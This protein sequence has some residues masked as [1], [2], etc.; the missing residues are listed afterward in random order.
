[1]YAVVHA[2]ADKVVVHMDAFLNRHAAD[3]HPEAERGTWF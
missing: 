2:N 3:M 1:L